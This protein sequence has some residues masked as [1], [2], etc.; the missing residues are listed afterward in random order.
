MS[1]HAQ[2]L[3]TTII[4]ESVHPLYDLWIDMNEPTVFESV[5]LTMPDSNKHFGNILHG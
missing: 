2:K 5:G 4:K 3:W 1:P